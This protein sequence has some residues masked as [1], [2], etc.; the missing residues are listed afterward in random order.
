[1]EWGLGT[2]KKYVKTKEVLAAGLHHSHSNVGSEPHLQ[3]RAQLSATPD[4]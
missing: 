2:E 3:P 4:P 1:M